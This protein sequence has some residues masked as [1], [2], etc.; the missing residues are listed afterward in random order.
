MVCVP[1]GQ[2]DPGLEH[3]LGRAVQSTVRV[4]KMRRFA[5]NCAQARCRERGGDPA[6]RAPGCRAV[7]TP[8]HP[9]SAWEPVFL[10][11]LAM[12]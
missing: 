5:G 3:K 7:C 11:V 6:P 1:P 4:G 10:H 2:G 12:V 9:C 8:Q